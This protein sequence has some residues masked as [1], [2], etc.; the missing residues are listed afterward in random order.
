M[1]EKGEEIDEY[2]KNDDDFGR[3]M[4]DLPNCEDVR[5]SFARWL[6]QTQTCE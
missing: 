6:S 4:D 2:V 5:R 1:Y 3:T